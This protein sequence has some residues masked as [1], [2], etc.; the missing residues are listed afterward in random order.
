MLLAGCAGGR[1]ADVLFLVDS[2]ADVGSVNFQIMKEFMQEVIR[3]PRMARS[4]FGVILYADTTTEM[5]T[6]AQND[7]LLRRIEEI[8]YSPPILGNPRKTHVGLVALQGAFNFASVALNRVRPRIGIL[9][10]NGI[11]DNTDETIRQARSAAFIGI[12]LVVLGRLTANLA[13]QP[14]VIFEFENIA[15][16]P[17]QVFLSPLLNWSDLRT[18]GIPEQTVQLI[19]RTTGT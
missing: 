17:S 12:Q 5:I 7:N 8:P 14:N 6:L 16:R 15:S 3:D 11:S 19:C 10:T 13:Q 1:G 2:S 9:L 18:L 4:S